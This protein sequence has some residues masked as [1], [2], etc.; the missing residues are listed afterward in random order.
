MKSEILNLIKT[1]FKR[2][3]PGDLRYLNAIQVSR[4][5]KEIFFFEKRLSFREQEVLE[6]LVQGKSYKEIAVELSIST[7]TV[8]KHASNIYKKTDTHNKFELKYCVLEYTTCSLK[9]NTPKI[10]RFSA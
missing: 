4:T 10:T 7:E 6:H 8:K 9:Q 1:C 2:K 5:D 3:D